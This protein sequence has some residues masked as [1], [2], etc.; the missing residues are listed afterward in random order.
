MISAARREVAAQY[1]EFRRTGKVRAT[2]GED[3]KI[4]RA[5]MRPKC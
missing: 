5:L 4:V 3:D 2:L 1:E